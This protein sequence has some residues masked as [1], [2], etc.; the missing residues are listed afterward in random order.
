MSGSTVKVEISTRMLDP[1]TRSLRS[2]LRDDN[3]LLRDDNSLTAGTW[4]GR[5]VVAPRSQPFIVGA[6]MPVQVLEYHLPDTR[7]LLVITAA[8]SSP[9]PS[10]VSSSQC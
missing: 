9:A 5:P 10:T 6:S 8:C 1:D 4:Y 2:L 3:P 7:C